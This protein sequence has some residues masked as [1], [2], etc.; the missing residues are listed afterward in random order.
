MKRS[1]RVVV[2]V[3]WG[4][5]VA[6]ALVSLLAPWLSPSELGVVDVT[7]QLQGPSDRYWLGTDENGGDVLTMM[8]YG[9]RVALVVG[10]ST[11]GICSGVGIV[12][13]GL[14]G[15]L[16][17]WVDEVMMRLTEVLMSFPGILLAILIIFVTQNPSLW[18]VIGALSVTGWS[19]YARLVRGSF[20]A[21]RHRDYVVAA[22]V[23]GASRRRVMVR[24]MLPNVVGPIVVQGT[25]GVAGAIL[26][27]ASL[28]FLG[29][30]PQESPS[31]GA[32]LDQGAS[33]FLLESHLAIIPG[34]AIMLTVLSIN[35]VGDDLR[36][37]LDPHG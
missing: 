18:A 35:F 31:W 12:V 32:L 2:M 16:G 17:G 15:Y 7:S 11:V 19:S 34:F 5:L 24:H 37:R 33:Y 3:S 8:L 30:G 9:G 27:E 4:F 29:L 28:S 23:M 10:L 6:L 20:L 1:Q 26:A 14:A 21:E 25:F 22:E 36:S 13:G